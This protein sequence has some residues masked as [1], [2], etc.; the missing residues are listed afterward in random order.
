MESA[1]LG[2]VPL[3]RPRLVRVHLVLVR[4]A[5]LLHARKPK[6][7]ETRAPRRRQKLLSMAVLIRLDKQNMHP[8]L[9]PHL[10]AGRLLALLLIA[11]HLRSTALLSM[12]PLLRC[13]V[14]R[15][16]KCLKRLRN[17]F[18]HLLNRPLPHRHPRRFHA[19]LLHPMRT[20]SDSAGEMSLSVWPRTAGLCGACC[21]KMGNW[22][23]LTETSWSSSFPAKGWSQAL[24]TGDAHRSWRTRSM[25][26]WVFVCTSVHRWDNPAVGRQCQRLLPMRIPL[27]LLYRAHQCRPQL[28]RPHLLKNRS[29]LGWATQTLRRTKQ[30]QHRISMFR[31]NRSMP[32]NPM[33][34]R[35][36][37][38]TI[39]ILRRRP[40]LIRGI[41]LKR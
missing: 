40:L 24:Q 20:L 25:T 34:R 6:R 12:L 3:P 7:A 29:P 4:H 26:S 18:P 2:A 31:R 21:P 22:A 9:S 5:K 11:M 15:S 1:W 10:G 23:P 30:H 36:Q 17:K 19:P 16:M 37:N 41:R 8:N 28:L 27:R 35:H 32:R 13:L 33:I 38:L 39:G 14:T